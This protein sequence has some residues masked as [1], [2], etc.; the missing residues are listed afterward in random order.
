M[1][2]LADERMWEEGKCPHSASPSAELRFVLVIFTFCFV[3]LMG[4]L[5]MPMRTDRAQWCVK[6]CHLAAEYKYANL[7]FSCCFHVTSDRF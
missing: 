4:Q 6:A 1:R 2:E 5:P 7:C 3:Y